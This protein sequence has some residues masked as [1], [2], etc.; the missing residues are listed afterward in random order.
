MSQH[1]TWPGSRGDVGGR[2]TRGLGR[3]GAAATGVLP[4]RFEHAGHAGLAAQAH[5][6]VGQY[7]HDA[8]RRHRGEARFVSHGQQ[9][10]ALG[11]AQG[12]ARG[13][14]NRLRPA[15]ARRGPSWAFQRCSVRTSM[16]AISQAGCSRAP[17]A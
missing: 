1:Q 4:V 8:R 17:V 12:M 13:R 3:L 7:R 11:R 6:L 14:A 5:P 9:R 15:I 2:R 10:R 16:P